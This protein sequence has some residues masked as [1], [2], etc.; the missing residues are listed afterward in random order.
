MGELEGTGS[1]QRP[2]QRGNASPDATNN[3][4]P[5]SPGAGDELGPVSM[6]EEAWRLYR[7]EDSMAH[8]KNNLFVTANIALL[9]AA[10]A[11]AG[12]VLT[13][14]NQRGLGWAALGGDHLLSAI[15]P[16]RRWSHRAESDPHPSV[17][18][19][20]NHGANR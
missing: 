16:H 19:P 14:S 1:A 6:Y 15:R 5:S 2:G 18:E 10:A 4:G 7:H 8:A 20:C 3:S 12:S 9:A 11:V 13:T 17:V